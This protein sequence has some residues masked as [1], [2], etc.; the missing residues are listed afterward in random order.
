MVHAYQMMNMLL[1]N[2]DLELLER[3][4][5]RVFEQFW[6]KNM[7]ELASIDFSEMR[8]L[9]DEFRELIYEMPFQI[10]QD[11]IFLARCVGILSGMCTG[12]DPEFN[13]WSHIAPYARKI[14]REE[15]SRLPANIIAEADRL[16]R[17]MFNLPRQLDNALRQL[18]RG[19][20]AVRTPEVSIQVNRLIRAVHGL[21][22]SIVCAAFFL[23][24]IQL[25][26]EGYTLFGIGSSGFGILFLILLLS[27]NRK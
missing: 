17:T 24:G 13:L 16:A 12:L 20:L 1:P 3:A 26:L 7:S 10:P 15:S 22:Y 9:A 25:I 5:E 21:S 8:G 11:I 19:E 6:G 18:E 4:E 2:A 14:M 27:I 23:G